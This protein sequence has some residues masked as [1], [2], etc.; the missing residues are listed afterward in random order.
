MKT[1]EIDDAVHGRTLARYSVGCSTTS[2]PE[3]CRAQSK[4]DTAW[5]EATLGRATKAQLVELLNRLRP[6][7][8]VFDRRQRDLAVLA[9]IV[10]H[11]FWYPVETV[12]ELPPAN[13]HREVWANDLW[14]L[15][16]GQRQRARDAWGAEH[17]GWK[18]APPS[19]AV[20]A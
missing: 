14:I 2:M 20:A 12:G 4:L 3:E 17:G 7:R 13:M 18:P 15:V 10:V 6:G 16:D 9:Q 1:I 11:A 8:P 19:L 5:L